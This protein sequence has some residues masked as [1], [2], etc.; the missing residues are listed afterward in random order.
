MYESHN[1]K[2]IQTLLEFYSL[3]LKATKSSIKIFLIGFC[4][5]PGVY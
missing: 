2:L 3:L 4:L 1:L 5:L